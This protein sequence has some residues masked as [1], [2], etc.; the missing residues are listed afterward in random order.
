MTEIR[1]QA[2]AVE[3]R[4]GED[5]GVTGIDLTVE[6]GRIHAIVGLNGAGKTTLMRLLLGMLRPQAGRTLIHGVPTCAAARSVWARVGHLVDSPLAYREVTVRENLVIAGRLR[7]LSR[8]TATV[9]ADHIAEEL[10]LT[11]YA[12]RRSRVLSM[13]NRQRLGVAAALVHHPDT[14]ILDEPTS[15]LD[16]SGVIRVRE[17]LRHRADD[18]AAI[19]VSS[20]HLDEVAR[21]ADEITVINRGRVVGGLDPGGTDLERAFFAQVREDDE[22]YDIRSGI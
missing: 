19:L 16:P 3:L 10:D 15:A 9:A 1:L 5:A 14:V 6:A 13:G 22:R 12:G 7:G 20:H 8:T 17:A 18:G 2:E 4:F 11:G 21:I